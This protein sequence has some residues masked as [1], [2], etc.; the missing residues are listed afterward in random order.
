MK[1]DAVNQSASEL[2]TCRR[3]VCALCVCTRKPKTQNT[4]MTWLMLYIIFQSRQLLDCSL[5][6]GHVFILIGI[7]RL[8][9]F[10]ARQ[11]FDSRRGGGG[12]PRES[13]RNAL[14]TDWM[15]SHLWTGSEKKPQKTSALEWIRSKRN[16]LVF[17]LQ[18]RSVSHILLECWKFKQKKRL[19]TQHVWIGHEWYTFCFPFCVAVYLCDLSSQSR[20]CAL[21]MWAL[22]RMRSTCFIKNEFAVK[23][24]SAIKPDAKG[25]TKRRSRYVCARTSVI[26]CV[27]VCVNKWLRLCHISIAAS[28]FPGDQNYM[29]V[30]TFAIAN[31]KMSRTESCIGRASERTS[32]WTPAVDVVPKFLS[33]REPTERSLAPLMLHGM[34]VRAQAAPILCEWVCDFL[35]LFVFHP[36]ISLLCWALATA[37]SQS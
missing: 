15:P 10:E 36:R 2:F 23:Y 22:F 32:E 17:D 16:S 35:C 25:F 13:V 11:A 27:C 7:I 34:Y 4:I 26:V 1:L 19:Q 3:C 33:P 20:V 31:M 30:F 12:G 28:P 37:D 21:C 18:R 5:A 9:L 14:R 29:H 8:F 6:V 24:K